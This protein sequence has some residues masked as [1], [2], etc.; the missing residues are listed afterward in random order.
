[1]FGRLVVLLMVLSI[2]LDNFIVGGTSAE[3][4]RSSPFDFYYYY[5]IFLV[6]LVIYIFSTKKFP[7][8]P[9]WLFYSFLLLFGVSI[10]VA[11]INGEVRFSMFKQIIGISFS[12]IAYYN[13][14]LY[15]K[16]DIEKLFKIY[17]NVALFV[18]LIG[19]VEEFGR[20][21]G[22]HHYFNG[23]P[24]RMSIGMYRV[25]SIMGEPYFLAVTLIPAF[26][27]YLN[28]F[29]GVRSFR[30]RRALIP[31]GIIGSCYIFTF[32]SAGV[33]GLILM[34]LLLLWN[35][36][37]FSFRNPKTIVLIIV[38]LG[39]SQVL[40]FK[41]LSLKE[42]QVRFNDSYKAFSRAGKLD[43]REIAKLNS[44]T[45]ALYSNY[46]IALQS[47]TRNP[48]TGSGLGTHEH[49]YVTYFETF[50]GKKFLIMYGMFN[51]KDGNSLFIRMLSETGLLGL[52]M[53]FLYIFKFRLK[54]KMVTSPQTYLYLIINQAVFIVFVI[55]LIRTG[56]YIGQG[57]FFFFFMYYFTYTL[58]Q[59]E[60]KVVE[61]N[62][63]LVPV[64]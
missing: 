7:F 46:L 22:F 59:K 21:A 58:T 61:T 36:G 14:M 60:M 57:F 25:Y 32:S 50:F 51:A 64:T 35:H 2:F 42:M 27:Y 52:F 4:R 31:F 19:V 3:A 62:T 11:S 39:F 63:D 33:M 43:K 18:A 5:V 26:Y 55:R 30:D 54:K 8:L 37:Y 40:N 1:M 9:R 53:V 56:N 47:F 45:F 17:L 48:L 29:F 28:R 44:S 6:F 49:T 12:A 15:V 38:V 13:L 41:E 20:I 16:L 24:K 34:V 23:D 10:F